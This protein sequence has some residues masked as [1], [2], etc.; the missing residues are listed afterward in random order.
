[1]SYYQTLNECIRSGKHL[2]SCDADGYCNYCGKQYLSEI[3]E[4]AEKIADAYVAGPTETITCR[5]CGEPSLLPNGYP[6]VLCYKCS[7]DAVEVLLEV[8][9]RY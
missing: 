2:K 5:L 7:Q 1:M 4:K 9:K 3:E 6:T 8:I